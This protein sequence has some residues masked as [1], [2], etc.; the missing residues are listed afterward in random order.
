MSIPPRSLFQSTI[1]NSSGFSFGYYSKLPFAQLLKNNNH[2]YRRVHLLLNQ[3]LAS[4]YPLII[5]RPIVVFHFTNGN[6]ISI[7]VPLIFCHLLGSSYVCR[8][9]MCNHLHQCFVKYRFKVSIFNILVQ[10]LCIEDGKKCLLCSMASLNG[11][12]SRDAVS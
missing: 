2:N 1:S 5:R 4:S 3:N 12:P 10:Y 6:S 7:S 11:R 8:C 9:T